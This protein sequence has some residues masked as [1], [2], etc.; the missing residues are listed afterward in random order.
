MGLSESFR[1]RPLARPLIAWMSGVVICYFLPSYLWYILLI[2][3]SLVALTVYKKL[4]TKPKSRWLLGFVILLCTCGTAYLKTSLEIKEFEPLQS[5]NGQIKLTVQI[6]SSKVEK[7]KT[8]RYLVKPLKVYTSPTNTLSKKGKLFLYFPKEIKQTFNI[9]EELIINARLFPTPD[10]YSSFGIYCHVNHIVGSLYAQDSDIE[11]TSKNKEQELSFS[12]LRLQQKIVRQIQKIPLSKD[13]AAIIAAMIIGEKQGISPEIRHIFSVAGIAHLLAV[14]GFHVGIIAAVLFL[15]FRIIGGKS[16][17]RKVWVNIV[18]I[19][20]IWLFI[21][22]CGAAT[23]A[24]RA[25]IMSTLYFIGKS[26]KRR[27]DPLNILITSA[28]LIEIIAPLQLFDIG[29]QLSYTAVLM[30]ILI[31]PWVNKHIIVHNPLIS[32]PWNL[33][34]VSFSA[35]LGTIPLTAFYFG[36][37]SLVFLLTNLLIVSAIGIF[38]PIVICYLL[39]SFFIEIPFISS[40]IAFTTQKIISFTSFMANLPNASLSINI[41]LLDTLLLYALIIS[42]IVLLRKPSTPALLIVLT[43]LLITLWFAPSLLNLLSL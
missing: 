14:S 30:I 4:I 6:I 3:G 13:E 2:G 24:I 7:T 33:A 25:G 37:V 17:V 35:Q 42:S 39:V 9:G 18:I 5:E 27:I 15:I 32:A 1:K 10:K 16:A 19:T 34:L 8:N 28:F 21:M 22:T 29:F 40:L 31:I 23:S 38:I 36:E 26:L 11:A 12:F 43:I 20:A 41:T